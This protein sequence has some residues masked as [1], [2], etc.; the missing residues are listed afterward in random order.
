MFIRLLDLSFVR[1][2]LHCS[3][4]THIVLLFVFYYHPITTSHFAHSIY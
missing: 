4:Y 3:Y 1:N 2:K